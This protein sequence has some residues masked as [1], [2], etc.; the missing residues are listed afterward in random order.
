MTYLFTNN[1]EIK[2]DIG[3][4]LPISRNTTTNST[5][6]P[7]YI[8]GEIQ[9]KPSGA[10]TT[11][12]FGEL[13][14]IQLNPVIQLDA[15]YGLDPNKFETY[16]ALGGGIDV[17]GPLIVCNTGTTQYGYGV[18]RSRRVVRY[19]PG[20]GALARFTAAFTTGVAGYT[21][22]AGLFNQE[23]ALQIGYDGTTFGVLR[24]NGGKA[25]IYKLQV[26][27]ATNASQTVTITL[28]GVAKN[29]TVISGTAAE[30]AT[31]IGSQSFPGWVI[32]YTNTSVVFLSESVGPMNGLFAISSTG[33]FAGTLTQ[34]QAGVAHTT[35]WTS[36]SS[37]NIDKLDGT[38]P[39]GVII[40]PTKLNVY[41]INFRWLGVGEIRYAMEDPNNGDM[42]FFHHEHYTNRHTTPHLDNPSLKLGYVAASLGGT[43]TNVIVTGASMMGGIEGNI[44]TTSFPL[45]ASNTRTTLNN[46]GTYYHLLSLHN[47]LI[48]N[49]KI[50]ARE[51]I[52]K[53]ISTAANSSASTPVKFIIYK[54]PALDDPF[55]WNHV[56]DTWSAA[57]I[58]TTASSLNP[59]SLVS[60]YEILVSPGA[61]TTIDLT[62]LR[63]TIPANTHISVVVVGS[64]V[65]SQADVT[66]NWV[67]D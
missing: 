11:T 4:P 5:T 52:L 12:A 30:N 57:S 49:N 31:V 48:L 59:A 39:S 10:T 54:N 66:L 24:Q 16:N 34:L 8:A 13:Y 14:G 47:R 19:R 15:I 7:I 26:T 65:I 53:S 41:Q 21:Q 40:D 29:I 43:G 22:R 63:I 17:D 56:D 42:I 33:N 27:T 1:Q 9:T 62:E 44:N 55:V 28:N 37:F 64:G 67:E 58:S 20:Q 38:G 25:V 2:N 6:N 3:N 18:I 61:A 32:E 45:A 51:I 50:N 36:Q 23:Q 60:I 46:S 35:N